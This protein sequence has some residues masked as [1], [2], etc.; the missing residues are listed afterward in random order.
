[1]HSSSF[2]YPFG[3]F[4]A[5]FFVRLGRGCP[6]RSKVFSCLGPWTPK[7]WCLTLSGATGASNIQVF[8]SRAPRATQKTTIEHA[9]S[10]FWASGHPKEGPSNR[11]S[12]WISHLTNSRAQERSK[13]THH[14][15]WVTTPRRSG[16]SPLGFNSL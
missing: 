2:G 13:Q 14:H 5:R 3:Y 11:Q 10:W 6:Q 8:L 16:R 9:R 7:R 1:M 15:H 12:P 4:M